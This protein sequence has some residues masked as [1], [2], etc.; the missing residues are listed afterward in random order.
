[1][2]DTSQNGGGRGR[3]DPRIF[4]RGVKAVVPFR[5]AE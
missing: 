1:M 4:L 3:D 5:A 2:A